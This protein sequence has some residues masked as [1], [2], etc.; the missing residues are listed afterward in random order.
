MW[1]SVVDLCCICITLSDVYK[2]IAGIDTCVD[3]KGGGGVK[4]GNLFYK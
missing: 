2:S 4:V 3:F 1:F